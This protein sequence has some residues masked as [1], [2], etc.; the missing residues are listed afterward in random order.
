LLFSAQGSG[1]TPEN[2][3][4]KYLRADVAFRQ[5]YALEP[6]AVPGLEKALKAPLNENDEKFVAAA[7]EA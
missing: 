4:V 7:A 6:D 1:A 5:A 3:A 2:A